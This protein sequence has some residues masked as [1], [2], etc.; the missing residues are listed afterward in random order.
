MPSLSASATLNC[1]APFLRSLQSATQRRRHG[2]QKHSQV[3]WAP[4][5]ANGRN[6]T[7]SSWP[8]SIRDRN[9]TFSL[10]KALLTSS[11]LMGSWSR[12]CWP[13]SRMISWS[14]CSA[15]ATNSTI[16]IITSPALSKN[17]STSTWLFGLKRRS[18][19]CGIDGF[20]CDIGYLC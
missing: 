16:L 6:T 11:T 14:L 9:V 12:S 8:N 2:G 7:L 3:I 10:I 20:D 5:Q 13:K 18:S 19:F 17:I 4:I 15:S 1:S